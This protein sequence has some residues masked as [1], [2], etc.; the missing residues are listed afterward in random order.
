[1]MPVILSAFLIVL[2][3]HLSQGKQTVALGTCLWTS[4]DGYS[5]EEKYDKNSQIC[6][7]QS[8][9]HK[10]KDDQNNDLKCCGNKTFRI[11]TEICCD[12]RVFNS[13][14]TLGQNA[15][16]RQ[17]CCN[18]KL[19]LET[20]QR[21]CCGNDYIKRDTDCC[22]GK[23]FNSSTHYCAD[24]MNIV[25]RGLDT[26]GVNVHYNRSHQKCCGD[27]RL[28]N[29][30]DTQGECCGEEIINSSTHQCC[31]WSKKKIIQPS[32][33]QCCGKGVYN[34]S[35]EICCRGNVF[36]SYNGVRDCCG[37]TFINKSNSREECCSLQRIN[38][39]KEICC[40]GKVY[41]ITNI[42]SPA[43]CGKQLYSSIEKR[44][45]NKKTLVSKTAPDCEGPISTK[46]SESLCGTLPYD[47]KKD[48][49]CNNKIHQEAKKH[50]KRCCDPTTQVYFPG[51]ETCC[52]SKVQHISL[53]C[54]EHPTTST[55]GI[56]SILTTLAPHLSGVCRICSSAWEPKNIMK[57]IKSIDICTKSAIE[58]KVNQVYTPR[59]GTMQTYPWTQLKVTYRV[60]LYKS[61]SN[62]NLVHMGKIFDLLLPCSC[63]N[64]QNMKNK[65]Y[66]L[67]TNIEFNKRD[68]FVGD[69][70]LIFPLK[71][72]VRKRI[73]VKSRKCP[74]YIVKNIKSLLQ[75][76]AFV[77]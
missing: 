71:R 23:P 8:G 76:S 51:N 50:G 27:S 35:S 32:S 13:H 41:S 37:D 20:N 69:G 57:S 70:D 53:R 29:I 15:G 39:D 40:D 36:P 25:L 65:S 55:T 43:C 7:E 28:H 61:S 6:C 63:M 74:K 18:T 34:S 11:D 33:G 24:D 4:S 52:S 17:I 5:S 68:I 42:T 48:L 77:R 9:V 19:H 21:E 22:N 38:R 75:K 46:S 56:T 30:P 44:C 26:C 59:S 14:I 66:L 54:S 62:N 10:S 45:C 12:N 64:I 3:V 1:M 16:Q 73:A 67:L 60:N 72:K 31:E 2:L 47:P 49:C 58:I